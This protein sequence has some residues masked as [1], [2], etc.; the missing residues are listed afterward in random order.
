[1]PVSA[2]LSSTKIML[3]LKPG[4]HGSTFGGNPLACRVVTAALQVVKDENLL[5]R[6]EKLG[7]LLRFKLQELK[8]KSNGVISEVRGKG[9]L[10]AIVIDESKANGRTAWDLCLLM[11][12]HGVLAK[13]THEHIIRLAPPLIISETDLLKSVDSIEKSLLELGNVP[14]SSH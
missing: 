9:L 11:K 4:S 12:D 3:C 7:Q 8:V 10:C 6:S 1:M 14:K 13:P 2:V 5:E